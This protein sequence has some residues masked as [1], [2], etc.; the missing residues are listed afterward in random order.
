MIIIKENFDNII[1]LYKYMIDLEHGTSFNIKLE[2]EFNKTIKD[3]S[4]VIIDETSVY[5]NFNLNVGSIEF[6]FYKMTITQGEKIYSGRIKILKN[7]ILSINKK[8]IK[9]AKRK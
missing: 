2:N 8:P 4:S 6:G 1:Y 9:F 5:Q 3:F 7:E